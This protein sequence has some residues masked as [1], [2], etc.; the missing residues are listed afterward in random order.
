MLDVSDITWSWNVDARS[1]E[2]LLGK[3][4]SKSGKIGVAMSRFVPR[5]VAL[6]E[7]RPYKG[8]CGLYFKTLQI[9]F[10]TEKEKN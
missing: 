2:S 10:F 5:T 1:Q 6:L 3:L 9:S 7:E 4:E 8:T